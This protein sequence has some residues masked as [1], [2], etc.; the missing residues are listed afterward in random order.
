MR[1]V[2]TAPVSLGTLLALVSGC[3]TLLPLQPPP[4]AVDISAVVQQI[5]EAVD[6]F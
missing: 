5:Q 4:G 1:I 6:H 3:N 2:R